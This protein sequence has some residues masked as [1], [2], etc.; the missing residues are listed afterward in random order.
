VKYIENINKGSVIFRKNDEI[1]TYYPYYIN[2]EISRYVYAHRPY[3][4]IENGGDKDKVK[5]DFMLEGNV[6]EK[7][8]YLNVSFSPITKSD[9]DA[10][11]EA[12]QVDYYQKLNKYDASIWKG[13]NAIE[14]LEEMKQFKVE[15]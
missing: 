9:Y 10:I 6:V 8:E 5:F 3:K 1:N 7:R 2:K 4:F 14:P 15:D 11:K 12:K 13:Y